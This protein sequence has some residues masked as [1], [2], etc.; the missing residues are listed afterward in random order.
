MNRSRTYTRPGLTL[1]PPQRCAK[2]WNNACVWPSVLPPN[3]ALMGA[4]AKAD[5]V[6]RFRRNAFQSSNV[7]SGGDDQKTLFGLDEL[8][9]VTGLDAQA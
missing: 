7:S 4:A 6:A 5:Q 9:P 1:E 8:N 2:S 3:E